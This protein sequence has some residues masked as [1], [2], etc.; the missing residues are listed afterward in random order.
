M[1]LTIILVIIVGMCTSGELVANMF[2]SWEPPTKSVHRLACCCLLWIL[3]L[4]VIAARQEVSTKTSR[5]TSSAPSGQEQ[6]ISVPDS[7]RCGK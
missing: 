5:N 3:A 7:A 1:S 2:F 4:V 6:V